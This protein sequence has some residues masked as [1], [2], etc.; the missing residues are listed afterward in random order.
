VCQ[1]LGALSRSTGRVDCL[2]A[3]PPTLV[4]SLADPL[5]AAN[6]RGAMLLL[7]ST[8][9]FSANDA[10]LKALGA[11]QPIF[12][13]ILWRGL[14]VT[15]ALLAIA[16]WSGA[17]RSLP[18]GRDARLLLMITVA[19]IVTLFAFLHALLRLPLGHVI[20]IPQ[21]IPVVQFAVAVVF[22]RESLVL[23]RLSGVVL[24]FGG[25]LL[26]ARP[27]A[28]DFDPA[29]LVA[30]LS[31]LSMTARDLLAR[32]LSS[33]VPSLLPALAA[34]LGVT[35]A[36]GLAS[37][38]EPTVTPTANGVGLLAGSALFLMMGSVLGLAG[39]RIGELGFVA[40]F[41][42]AALPFALAAGFVVFQERPDALA[43]TGCALV[44]V[45]GLLTSLRRTQ[46]RHSPLP[47]ASGNAL[48]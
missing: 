12:Q 20:G 21:T 16:H 9:A 24:A 27:A 43:I 48:R 5:L 10:C 40:P 18:K 2:N 6:L 41:R 29:S 32:R 44:V 34:A 47:A 39:V 45:G 7:A 28:T 3:G 17:L 26:I 31:V 42:F 14:L 19:E 1:P 38:A 11:S 25:V 46:R 4:A 13:G 8:A 36:A 30:F 37:I 33:E 15:T 23:R 22:L 35:L